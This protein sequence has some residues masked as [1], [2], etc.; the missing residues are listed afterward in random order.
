MK[1]FFAIATGLLMI[2]ACAKEPQSQV[3][4]TPGT[5]PEFTPTAIR[6]A[7]VMTKV[8]E[9]AFENGDAIGLTVTRGAAGAEAPSAWASNKK[10]TF[11][12]LEFSSDLLWYPEGTDEA[13]LAAYYPYIAEGV[14]ATF[15]VAIDQ[16]DGI[17]DS[18]LIAA[19]KSGVL[20]TANAVTMPFKHKLSRL[21]VAI[22]N[23]AGYTIEGLTLKGIIPTAALAEDFT[24]TASPDDQP[25]DITAFR[26]DDET[27]TAIVPPQTVAIT[28]EVSAAGKALSQKLAESTLA[29]GKKYTINVIVNQEDIEIVLSGDI[30]DWTD[31]GSLQPDN[32]G[33]PAP[34]IQ[35]E[36]QLEDGYFTYDN[37]RYNVVK[38]DDGKWW[39]AQNLAFL[40]AGKTPATDLSAVTAGVFAP[41]KINEGQTAAE[42]TTD[43]DVV[44]ANGYLYQSEFALGLNVGDLTSVAQAEALEGAQGICPS[45]WHIPT[46]DDIVGIVGKAVSPITTNTD[47]PYY[48]GSNGSIAML[49]AD[50]F[51]IDAYGA[52]SIQDNTKTAGTFMGWAS[53]YPDKLSSCMTIGSSYAGVTYNTSGDETSGVK[54][55]QFWGMMPMTNKSSEAQYTCNGTK[56][57]YR[58]AGPVRCVRDE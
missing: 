7:P 3:T 17:Q 37:V 57:S 25:A 58:I 5:A 8:T 23:N 33:T 56:V 9:T 27:F 15:T 40:P 14:P 44:A 52:I 51:N 1:K 19:V 11:N 50:G 20:P 35:F 16:A 26:V 53:G 45:G 24:A 4:P 42:F 6:I 29:A 47:A 38:L 48:D 41:L 13:T 30:E 36:E 46:I 10:L 49:N 21:V 18:D 31:G 2:A 39:M 43:P 22:T 34:E 55:L 12:G 28:A 54:N 32:S